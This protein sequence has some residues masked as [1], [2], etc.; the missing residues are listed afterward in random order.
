MPEPLKLAE[1][2]LRMQ[3]YGIRP[4][5]KFGQNILCDFNLL[6]AIVADAEIDEGDCVLEI[7]TGAGSLTGYLCDA[8]GLVISVEVDPGMFDLSRD[9]LAGVGNLVQVHV[10]ALNQQGRGLN[11]ELVAS[12]AEYMRT[13][14]LPLLD[15]GT[16]GS[17]SSDSTSSPG[18]TRQ[19]VPTVHSH[20]SGR[21]PRCGRLKLVANLPY[22][23]ATA[24]LIAALESGLPFERILVMVQYDVAEKLAAEPGT[25]HW[26]L[27]SLL[28]WCFADALIKRRVPAKVFW[29]KP[30]VESALLEILPRARR[31][32]MQTYHKLRRLA[33]V[34]FQH[35]RKAA[36]NALAL[37]LEIDSRQTGLW[38]EACGGEPG[39]RPEQLSPAVLQS[40]AQHDE[41]E[42]LV[43][44][45]MR[46]H[47]DQLAERAARLA[48][49]AEWKQRV[50]G[51]EE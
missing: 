32:E 5:K 44:K 48:R 50:Y 19:R 8:A 28:R 47:E 27:P 37:A 15:V 33:H 25:Q 10:D 11:D 9:V 39:A 7:G 4:K 2:K 43:R 3:A 6:K 12:L 20:L 49:R 46:L 38:I 36:P 21:P 23:V 16:R 30:K 1:L 29:P 45:A 35:R 51:E 31:P 22:S 24:V 14:E 18:D 17:V 26:G 41:V 42:P 40:L 13:G 34:L